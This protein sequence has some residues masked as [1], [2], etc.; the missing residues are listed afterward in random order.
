M[1]EEASAGL[2]EPLLQPR[3]GSPLDGTGRDELAQG[4]A[5]LAGGPP[6]K[7]RAGPRAMLL[8]HCDTGYR[9]HDLRLPESRPLM[10]RYEPTEL[11]P[12]ETQCKEQHHR[13]DDRHEKS[14][15]VKLRPRLRPVNEAADQAPD[16]GADDS[17]DRGGDEAHV[18]SSGHDCAG[19][20]AGEEPHDDGPD[21][22]KHEDLLST[23]QGVSQWS[24][25]YDREPDDSVAT[26]VARASAA[27]R[28][29]RQ[30]RR[31]VPSV[32]YG[33]VSVVRG[34]P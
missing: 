34:K 25:L 7:P 31:S 6:R 4:I 30:G 8:A 11:L 17:D 22:V 5:D 14:R 32:T 1:A 23:F 3:Q 2:E 15:R 24:L 28:L 10:W 18:I 26:C 33:A 13:T 21:E 16:H 29:G 19:D 20:E 12:E 27:E 9:P